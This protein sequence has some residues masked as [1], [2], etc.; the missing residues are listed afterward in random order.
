LEYLSKREV[1]FLGIYAFISYGVSSR[2]RL[3]ITIFSMHF[4]SIVGH[5]SSLALMIAHETNALT[6]F[7]SAGYSNNFGIAGINATYDCK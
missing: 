7:G 4:L 1:L 2:G 3:F 5:W 6:N